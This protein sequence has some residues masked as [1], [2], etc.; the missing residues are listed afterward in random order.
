VREEEE[1]GHGMQEG[2]R[3]N[4]LKAAKWQQCRRQ[5]G[6]QG[7]LLTGNRWAMKSIHPERARL[8][9]DIVTVAATSNLATIVP[10]G[11]V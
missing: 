6:R 10:F 4:V 3:L 1:I 2:H 11:A 5:N 9:E 7:N 8:V